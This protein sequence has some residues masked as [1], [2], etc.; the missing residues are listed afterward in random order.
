[1]ASA[2]EAVLSR[3]RLKPRAEWLR[4]A[5]AAFGATADAWQQA[6]P[7]QV[8]AHVFAQ[9]LRAD[10]KAALATA[11][12]PDPLLDGR[13]A[14]PVL[15]QVS[16]AVNVSRPRH[17]SMQDCAPAQRTLKLQLTDGHRTVSGFELEPL[18]QLSIA[19]FGVKVLLRD[20]QVQGSMLLLQKENVHVLGGG[21]PAAR[22]EYE[23]ALRITREEVTKAGRKRR[24]ED[25]E[26]PARARP[27][28]AAVSQQR[29]Q[30][31]HRQPQ[32]QP[33]HN[34]PAARSAASQ[35][36]ATLPT[37]F[38]TGAPSASPVRH[39]S[40]EPDAATGEAPS[41]SASSAASAVPPSAVQRR[42]SVVSGTAMDLTSSSPRTAPA[43]V[44]KHVARQ[45]PQ[46]QP[47]PHN[48]QRGSP[49]GHLP[50]SLHA[51]IRQWQQ[52]PDVP[53]IAKGIP[54]RVA[55]MVK[56]QDTP[57]GLVWKGQSQYYCKVFLSSI[58]PDDAS[59]GL[60]RT[61]VLLSDAVIAEFVAQGTSCVELNRRLEAA[62][63]S[64]AE[65]RASLQKF[66]GSFKARF[67]QM[68]GR[69]DIQWPGATGTQQ[70]HTDGAGA[71]AGRQTT[72]GTVIA[73]EQQ[74]HNGS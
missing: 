53:M 42:L 30:R 62:R 6:P 50:L 13:L 43:S 40:D 2:F 21:L 35:G 18:P 65:E 36:G 10:L 27:R 17:E 59:S 58:A 26:N 39:G 31:D 22:A 1:M 74:H 64:T 67:A 57:Q 7:Q 20:V 45:Q 51:V 14:G 68:S 23:A 38:N 41:S 16:R 3:Q 48:P 47:Q 66:F 28:T 5:L 52:Q 9:L 4:G 60:C 24:L 56:D 19:D 73:F 70:L 72:Y 12:L 11:A 25:I 46:P 32:Q 61:E 33:Q 15:L 29:D 69:F 71:G 34:S 37:Q 8:D 63:K 49:R 44:V 55:G 54:A